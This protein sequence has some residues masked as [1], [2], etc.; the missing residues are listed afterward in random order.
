MLIWMGSAVAVVATLVNVWLVL[1]GSAAS[2][3]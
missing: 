3:T 1:V 2:M